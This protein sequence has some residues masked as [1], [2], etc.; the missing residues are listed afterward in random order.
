MHSRCNIHNEMLMHMMSCQ[1]FSSCNTRGVTVSMR[2]STAV[3]SGDLSNSLSR[4]SCQIRMR[5]KKYKRKSTMVVGIRR[6][7]DSGDKSEMIF[8]PLFCF[9]GYETEN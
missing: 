7:E 6:G 5:E 2:R 9:L 4:S 3:G 1:S 8:V